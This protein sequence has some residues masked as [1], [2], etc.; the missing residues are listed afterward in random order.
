MLFGVSDFL[1]NSWAAHR[2]GCAPASAHQ[3]TSP[4]V[5]EAFRRWAAE[6]ILYKQNVLNQQLSSLPAAG[7][8]SRKRSSTGFPEGVGSLWPKADSEHHYSGI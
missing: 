1:V 4:K 8:R 2:W 6:L 3:R 7:R 5:S